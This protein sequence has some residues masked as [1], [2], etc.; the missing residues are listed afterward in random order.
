[1]TKDYR[2]CLI[3]GKPRKVIVQ[4]GKIINRNPSKDELKGLTAEKYIVDY[5]PNRYTRQELISELLRFKK[6]YGRQPIRREWEHNPDYPNRETIRKEF[7][8]WDKAIIVAGFEPNGSMTRSRQGEIQTISETEGAIDLSGQN[9]NSTCD[10]ICSE[11][12]FDTKSAC[13]TNVY[14]NWGWQ[15]YVSVDQLEEADYLLLRAYEDKDFTKKPKYK[16]R[17]PI[18]FMDNKTNIF[19]YRDNRGVCNVYT[20]KEYEHQ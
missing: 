3:E 18:E 14:G 5:H 12:Q 20:M 2:I 13:L 1:M 9:R 15:Y 16:W 7:G 4:D 8:S 17:I 11:G 10:G 19:I 6:E